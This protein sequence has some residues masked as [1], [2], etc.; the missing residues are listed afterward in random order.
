MQQVTITRIEPKTGTGAKGDW[1]KLGI[2]TKEHGDKWLGCFFSKYNE[3]GL[4]G[5]AVG[6]TVEIV[7]TPSPDGK[8]LN[9]ALPSRLDKL[10]QR[11]AALEGKDTVSDGGYS[12]GKD[13]IN[14]DDIPF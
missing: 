13:D 6:Q 3:K 9:F 5:L 11:V 7:V 14:P 2:Q 4:N 1:K 8:F 12:D 10:E